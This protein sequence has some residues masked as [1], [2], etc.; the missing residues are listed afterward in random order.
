MLETTSCAKRSFFRLMAEVRHLLRSSMS[1]LIRRLS[2]STQRPSTRSSVIAGRSGVLTFASELAFILAGHSR[3][4]RCGHSI[5]RFAVH[6]IAARTR[7]AA[8]GIT[9]AIHDKHS[10]AQSDQGAGYRILPNNV[11]HRRPGIF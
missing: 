3:I 7:R 11:A 2:Y 5:T 4:S 10:Q 1:E 8:V 6:V 9:N